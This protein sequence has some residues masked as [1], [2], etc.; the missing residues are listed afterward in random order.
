MAERR[1]GGDM[2]RQGVKS[3]ISIGH[4]RGQVDGLYDSV[5][6]TSSKIMLSH[7]LYIPSLMVLWRS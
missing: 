1:Q 3:R 4:N 2:R 5:S 7:S 6:A